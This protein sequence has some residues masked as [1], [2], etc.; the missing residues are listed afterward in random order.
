MKPTGSPKKLYPDISRLVGEVQKV[1]G[2]DVAT[3]G[4]EGFMISNVA[5]WIDAGPLLNPILGDPLRG[6][7]CGFFTEVAGPESS[8]KT[9]LGYYLLGQAQKAGCIS[10]LADVEVSYDAKWARLQGVNSKQLIRIASSYVNAKGK[11]KVDDLDEEFSKWEFIAKKSW[12]MFHRPQLLLVDSMAA[13]IPHEELV[14]D[15][16]DRNVAPV[17]RALSKNFR[18]FHKVLLETKTHCIFIN[19]MRSKIGV[20]FGAKEQTSGGRAKN[21][22]FFVRVEVSKKK[23][24][25]NKKIGP[26][27]I[28]SKVRNTKN[29]LAPPFRTADFRISFTKGI[30]V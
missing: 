9:T 3:S 14:G 20:M 28:L 15:F 12:R 27:A 21:F 5:N 16:G 1:F 24:L 2:G 6:L 18:K 11:F 8:G 13:L 29:K 7:P 26:F 25:K 19:Q 30:Q 4:A 10:I 17:A 22:Y 23:T